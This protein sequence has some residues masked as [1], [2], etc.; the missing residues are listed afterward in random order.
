[1]EI[2]GEEYYRVLA[3]Q[4]AAESV[5]ALGRPVS[6]VEDI[7]ELPHVGGTTAEVIR[8]LAEDRTP[9]ILAELL[10]EIPP[11][12]VE[13]TRLPGVGPRTAGKLWKELGVESVEEVA[14]LDVD[15][16]SSLEGFGRKSAEKILRAAKTYNTQ[17]RRMLLDE[18][19]ALAEHMLEFVRSHPS[20]VQ[21]E[22]AGSLRRQRPRP[23]RREHRP[24]GPR[25]CL[26]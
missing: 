24:E 4:R 3:Y 20:T 5:G 26:R 15:Q 23:R 21:A 12:L 19:T 14:E 1:M 25:R 8:D 9:Q 16:I 7:K 18:A 6:E 13:M 22:V 17:E 10:A 11:G 2:K